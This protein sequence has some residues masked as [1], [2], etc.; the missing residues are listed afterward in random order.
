MRKT[1]SQV[2]RSL[3]ALKNAQR[4]GLLR[5]VRVLPGRNACDAALAQ[6]GVNYSGNTVPHLP[7]AQCTRDHCECK[8]VAVGSDQ[9]RALDATGKSPSKSHH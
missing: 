3:R 4:L 1:P 2:A 7:L 6:F 5:G 9:L 8:Y